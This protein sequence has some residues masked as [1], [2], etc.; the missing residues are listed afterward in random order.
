VHL[1]AFRFHQPRNALK[2]KLTLSLVAHNA[3][4][5]KAQR[6]G[7]AHGRLAVSIIDFGV[8]KFNASQSAYFISQHNGAIQPMRIGAVTADCADVGQGLFGG[9]LIHMFLL[10]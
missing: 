9:Q 3:G 8:V 6:F 1:Q 7:N 4:L 5:R 10:C 2:G